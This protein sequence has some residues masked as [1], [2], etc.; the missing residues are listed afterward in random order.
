MRILALVTL[1]CTLA[2][3]AW[4]ADFSANVDGVIRTYIRPAAERMAVASA[5][6]PD[7][8]SVVCSEPSDA[9]RSA[10][11]EAYGET[12]VSFARVGFLRFGPLVEEDRL[13]RLAFLPDARGTA[14]RQIRKVFAARDQK[15]TDAATLTGKSVALQ[16]LTA[17][18]LIAFNRDGAVVLGEAGETREFTCQYAQAIAVNVAGISDAVSKA[19]NDPNGYSSVLLS[20][21]PDHNQ[22]RS[23]QDAM[24][25]IFNALVTGLIV[26]KDQD[27]LPALGKGPGKPKPHRVPFSRSGNGLV[28]V[29][30]ELDGIDA[31]L[32]ALEYD[33]LLAE[34]FAWLPSSLAFEFQNAQKILGGIEPPVRTSLRDNEAYGRFKVLLLT[35]NSLRDTIALELAGAL[36]LA[37]GFNALDGD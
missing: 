3:P 14:Q 18:Q 25:T 9:T 29:A 2:G 1:C 33:G 16:G 36:S 15:V 17:L 28:Y 8:V 24:E 35:I 6:L 7:A 4:P 23:S 26:T 11:A 32:K 27:I 34:E 37:G 30:A 22:I 20:P 13:S 5:K 12:V 31:A 21:S 19:W 10:F